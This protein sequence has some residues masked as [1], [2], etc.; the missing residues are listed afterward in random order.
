MRLAGAVGMDPLWDRWSRNDSLSQNAGEYTSR[1]SVKSIKA[2]PDGLSIKAGERKQHA[3]SF[4]RG[5]TRNTP[6][7]LFH[8]EWYNVATEHFKIKRGREGRFIPL[9]LASIDSVASAPRLST[10]VFGYR[11]QRWV[12]VRISKGGKIQVALNPPG[13]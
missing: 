7:F 3:I 8:K 6:D 11:S 12:G 9:E 2:M 10:A 5:L 13:W 1:R 4:P